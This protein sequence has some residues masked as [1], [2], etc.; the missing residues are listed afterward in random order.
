MTGA[1]ITLA[2]PH[3]PEA[4]A[5]IEELDRYLDGLYPA[6][7]NFLADIDALAGTNMRFLL[8]RKDGEAVGCVALRVDPDGYGEIKRMYVRPDQRGNGLGRHLLARLEAEAHA[9]GLRAIRL[10]T[11]HRQPEAVSLYRRYGFTDR[12]PFADYPDIPSSLFL[13]KALP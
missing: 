12:G 6:E 8:A 9:A 13:E 4:V 10:E 1:T 5:L 3:L 7:A 2:D 11:G